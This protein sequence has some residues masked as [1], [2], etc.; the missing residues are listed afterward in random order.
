MAGGAAISGGADAGFAHLIDPNKKWYNNRRLII[1]NAWLVL[2]LIT[3][4]TNGYDG[5]MM[6]GLQSLDQW[7]KD[8]NF[9]GPSML[10]LLT[11]IQN[12]GSLAAY[13]FAPYVTDG[14]G[15][16]M[17]I[18]IGALIM[19]GGTAL[20]TASQTVNMFIGAR[21]RLP[22]PQ[23]FLIGFG[24]SFAANAAPLLV[25]ELSYPSYR[26]AL[27]SA[28]NSLWYSG[29][30]VMG[31]LRDL[32]DPKYMVL[33][34]PISVAGCTISAPALLL[35]A[36]ESPR[37]LVSKGREKEALRTLA[38]YHADG[39]EDDPLVKY[40]FEEIKAAITFERTV[41]AHVGYKSL[42]TSKGNLK[43]MRIIIAI[44]FFSQW[45]GNGLPSYFL[46]RVLDRIGI[47]DGFDQLLINGILSIWNLCWALLA[48]FLVE[49]AGRRLLFITSAVGML[50]FWTAQTICFAQSEITQRPEAGHGLIAFMF[51]FFAAYDIAFSPLI[52]SYTVE[53]L[54]FAIRAKGFNVFNLT[55]SAAIIFNQYVNPIALDAITWK[56]YVVYCCWLVFEL[57]YVYLFVVETKGLTL[58]ETAALFDG[59]EATERV[60]V[61]GHKGEAIAEKGS[62]SFHDEAPALDKA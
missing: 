55:V 13:P 27:T 59:E 44:A 32:P 25:T 46:N 28:Y 42:F 20:Q 54:P 41:A 60:A 16:R 24:L 9:P 21:Y 22:C 36:P 5:S 30:I 29:A 7:K 58:E 2:L 3:S 53:I 35:F 17:G 62:G 14:L 47:T 37:W 39:N 18:M 48:S 4:S 8:F 49:R 15:R 1:L 23:R 33:A 57:V 38:Y 45:S 26:A 19:C 61:A 50:L 12:I 52:V 34:N 51:L 40:E 56:Y 10:G 43:R 31:Y 6:N 11:A